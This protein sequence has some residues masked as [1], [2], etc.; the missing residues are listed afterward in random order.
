MKHPQSWIRIAH[1]EDIPLREGRAVEI[2]GREIAI[3]NLGERFL[4]IENRC[5]HRGGPL[6]DGIVS[7]GTVVCPLHAWRVDLHEGSVVRPRENACVST[8]PVRRDDGI[9]SIQ[10]P[11]RGRE[12]APLMAMPECTAAESVV[13]QG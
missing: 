11:E 6:S 13:V 5:P 4:A 12:A 1:A 8:Y 3:F 10:M 7:G 9:I 2:D